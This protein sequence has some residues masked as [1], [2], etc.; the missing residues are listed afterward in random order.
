MTTKIT[1]ASTKPRLPRIASAGRQAIASS[2]SDSVARYYHLAEI[3]GEIVGAERGE[4]ARA[5]E[6][7]GDQCRSNRML[8]AGADSTDEQRAEQHRKTG[9]GAGQAIAEAGQRGAERKHDRAADPFGKQAGGNLQAGH[10]ADEHAAQ[11]AERRIVETKLR[12]PQRQHDV[13]QVGIA[14]VQRMRHRRDRRRSALVG[15]KVSNSTAKL[16]GLSTHG[17][18]I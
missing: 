1:T 6:G 4:R 12:L 10:G 8:R 11:H 16:L 2:I 14:I 18:Q 13:D 17:T 7:T 5:G 3:A 9:T 15:N